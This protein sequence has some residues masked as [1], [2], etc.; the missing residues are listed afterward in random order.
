MA[1]GKF[2][3][4][5]TYPFKYIQYTVVH[6]YSCQPDKLQ[7]STTIETEWCLDLVLK[8]GVARLWFLRVNTLCPPHKTHPHTHTQHMQL[9]PTS[10]ITQWEHKAQEGHACMKES[11][12]RNTSR[13]VGIDF[14][15]TMS[16]K[17]SYKRG[18][19]GLYI[20]LLWEAKLRSIN[21]HTLTQTHPDHR[22]EKWEYNH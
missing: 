19:P 13:L 16:D 11:Q 15:P 20:T 10:V 9:D 21:T 8:Q 4:M 3:K 12:E 22:N 1:V 18:I 14:W 2:A 5:L 17:S 6:I 7:V